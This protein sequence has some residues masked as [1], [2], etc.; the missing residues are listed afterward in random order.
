[1]V[2]R[3]LVKQLFISRKGIYRK[4][5]LRGLITIGLKKDACSQAIKGIKISK[6]VHS[7]WRSYDL[8]N[9]YL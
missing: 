9:G 1:M 3:N 4:T 2:G 8:W 5:L 7:S 6:N